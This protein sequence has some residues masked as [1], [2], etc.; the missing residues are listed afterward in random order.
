M[1]LIQMKPL[2]AGHQIADN[3]KMFFRFFPSFCS[4]VLCEPTIKK[5]VNLPSFKFDGKVF[6]QC[7]LL[8]VFGK[9]FYHDAFLNQISH[10]EN[11]FCSY[12]VGL[13]LV[14]TAGVAGLVQG[15]LF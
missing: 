15:G 7:A 12:S 8:F 9:Y 3:T 10:G 4:V 13:V 6:R 11:K 14:R 2:L 5:M 1:I